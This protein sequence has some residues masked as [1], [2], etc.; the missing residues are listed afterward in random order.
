MFD[1]H[2]GVDCANYTVTHFHN[3]IAR[4][5]MFL[6]DLDEALAQAFLTTD[7]MFLDKA[8]TEVLFAHFDFFEEK[9]S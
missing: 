3:N 1:G 6:S 4:Q 2:G 5:E 7:K 9:I 8:R